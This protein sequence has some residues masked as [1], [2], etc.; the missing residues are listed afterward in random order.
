[1]R[2]A[3]EFLQTLFGEG[4]ARRY[5]D[6]LTALVDVLGHLNDIAVARRVLEERRQSSGD[7]SLHHG[8][9]FVEGWHAGRAALL[10]E[11]AQKGWGDFKRQD[12]FWK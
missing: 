6:S 4:K 9:G 11:Q 10:E 1:M 12:K 3:A 8:V 5:L 2:Y 7:S